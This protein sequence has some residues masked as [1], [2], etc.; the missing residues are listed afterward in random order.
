MVGFLGF[1]GSAAHAAYDYNG[2]RGNNW[3][4]DPAVIASARAFADNLLGV[5]RAPVRSA[6][7]QAADNQARL[8]AYQAEMVR[9]NASERAAAL[10]VERE[11]AIKFRAED[12]RRNPYDVAEADVLRA[13]CLSFRRMIKYVQGE[14]A[15]S[16]DSSPLLAR[17]YV[18]D[19]AGKIQYGFKHDGSPALVS[20]EKLYSRFEKIYNSIYKGDTNFFYKIGYGVVPTVTANIDDQARVFARRSYYKAKKEAYMSLMNE[21]LEELRRVDPSNPLL[22]KSSTGRYTWYERGLATMAKVLTENGLPSEWKDMVFMSTRAEGTE[23]FK[24]LLRQYPR[25]VQ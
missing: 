12:I 14:I 15:K 2:Q 24:R 1:V 20:D 13:S 18:K 7:Q 4:S 16:S 21:H 3:T 9:I 23:T 5:Q 22:V 6:A 25:Q 17:L 10:R 8:A 11:C 19:R